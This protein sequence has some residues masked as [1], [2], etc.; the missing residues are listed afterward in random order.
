MGR[1]LETGVE[2]F[3]ITFADPAPDR[4]DLL[5]KRQKHR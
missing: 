4:R 2:R 3:S 5:N 1:A